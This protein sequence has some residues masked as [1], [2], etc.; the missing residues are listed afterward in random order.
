MAA[1]AQIVNHLG[2]TSAN[3]HRR[4]LLMSTAEQQQT[5]PYV[6]AGEAI[7]FPNVAPGS[8]VK[9]AAR[10]FA[11][12]YDL[13]EGAAFAFAAA[14]VDPTEER[15]KVATKDSNDHLTL[16]ETPS[17]LFLACHHARVWPALVSGDGG[18]GRSRY[19]IQTT[20]TNGSRNRP[21][22]IAR[23]H[24]P[25]IVDYHSGSLDEM[26]IAVRKSAEEIRS[27]QLVTQI[28]QNPRG[29]WNPPVVVLA[30][31]FVR[32]TD[33]NPEEHWFAHTIEGST[34][35]EGAHELL[36]VEPGAPLLRSQEPLEHLR[37]VHSSLT[38]RFDR[39][40]TS[41]K[42]LAASRAVTMPAL[43]V[44]AVVDSE[45][46]KVTDRFP[47]VVNDYVESVHVQPRPFTPVAQS[48][49]LGER[50]LLTLRREGAMS[51]DEVDAL[52][53]REHDIP[54]KPSVRAAELVHA[55]CDE[56]ND[57][58]VRRIVIT[59]PRTRLTKGRRAQLI[60][61]LVVRQFDAPA[62]AADR[63]LMRPFTPDPL[64][65]AP[66]SISGA[67]SETLC[68]AALQAFEEETWDDAALELMARGGP[69]LCAAGLL[70]SDQ[71]STVNGIAALRG[72]VDKVVEALACT[73]GGIK[74]L[75]DAVAW[76]DG[77][78]QEKPRKY[79]P[80][81]T[82]VTSGSAEDQDDE[83]YGT[84]WRTGNMEVRALAFTDGKVPS[85]SHAGD[86]EDDE[87]LTQEQLYQ[88]AE[89]ALLTAIDSAQTHARDMLAM[90]DE[91]GRSLIKRIGMADDQR[92]AEVPHL[93]SRMWDRY[94][95]DELH[96][97]DDSM[98]D[99]D[100]TPSDD[101]AGDEDE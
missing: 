95:P 43:V 27:P 10:R 50:F 39:L 53:G 2:G 37:E 55:V 67:D 92:Y 69:A 13:P 32:Q 77:E 36:G 61:P 34:R 101:L 35:V 40:P 66:W 52:L 84:S 56:T 94:G 58:Y 59:E 74:L 21:W 96:D 75:A 28:A 14:T 6:L 49:V 97:L 20:G 24:H 11:M 87:E 16:I 82:V 79:R 57:E 3:S 91:H 38:D 70:L 4:T 7:D 68:A 19:A 30:R 80:D 25:A 64:L 78:T 72:N 65:N 51:E 41:N 18:N 85:A 93:L 33:G 44:V 62:E 1:L 90:K 8:A 46:N 88:R 47:E 63:A 73:K 98:P 89:I 54:G 83:H 42:S 9:N 76:A 100:P 5:A 81:G 22:P 29:I 31:A 45:G 99:G 86:D 71:G 17:G 23:H 15:N 48:N 12:A 60:G 26:V